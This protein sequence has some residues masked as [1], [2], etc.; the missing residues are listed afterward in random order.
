MHLAQSRLDLIVRAKI[1]Q[2]TIAHDLRRDIRVHSQ[3]LSKTYQNR[4]TRNNLSYSLLLFSSGHNTDSFRNPSLGHSQQR[5]IAA[6][7]IH[8]NVRRTQ[9]HPLDNLRECKFG[10]RDAI[11]G[12]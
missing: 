3:F 9:I 11:P 7:D 8:E 5:A 4:G 12:G 6:T 10:L 1:N 2:D